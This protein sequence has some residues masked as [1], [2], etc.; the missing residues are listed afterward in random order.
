MILDASPNLDE[1]IVVTL[2][3]SYLSAKE[4]H[5]RIDSQTA[6]SL[7]GIY[8]E[9]NKL[10]ENGVVVKVKDKYGLRIPWAIDLLSLAEKINHHYVNQLSLQTLTLKEDE[11][12]IWHFNDLF[13]LNDFWS[14]ILLKLVKEVK[15]KTMLGWN[16]HPWFHLIQTEQENQYIRS[17]QL[18]NVRLYLIVGG[19]NYLD[20]WPEKFWDINT[21]EYAFATSSF[22]S[23][24]SQ[25]INIIGDYVLTVK[26]DKQTTEAIEKIYQTVQSAED[27]DLAE[28][29]KVFHSKVK[30]SIWLEKNPKKATILRK[31]FEKYFGENFRTL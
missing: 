8:K 4:L 3:N 31:R 28:I 9:L 12:T 23:N 26:L 14:Q 5:Q 16:P 10:Q 13:H 7:R 11:R 22:E 25:Y 17:L 1:K 24:Q 20:K 15:S 2:A 29:L 27:I 19:K 6:Y 18:S 21:V 30:A